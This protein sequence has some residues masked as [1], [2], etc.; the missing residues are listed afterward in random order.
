LIDFG[1]FR[2]DLPALDLS[3]AVMEIREYAQV[4]SIVPL[5]WIAGESERR[6][7]KG[8]GSEWPSGCAWWL[9]HLRNLSVYLVTLAPM[10]SHPG[11][12][13]RY[14]RTRRELARTLDEIERK[15]PAA[16]GL[17]QQ[18]ARQVVHG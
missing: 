15:L 14:L 3:Q 13:S 16:D 8:Y 9:P 4:G 11:S 6:F 12:F 5:P 17:H 18:A 10:R 1:D 7:R 2:F